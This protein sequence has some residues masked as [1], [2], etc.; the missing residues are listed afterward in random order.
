M[1]DQDGR[2]KYEFLCQIIFEVNSLDGHPLTNII[3]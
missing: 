1:Y 2:K 3:S